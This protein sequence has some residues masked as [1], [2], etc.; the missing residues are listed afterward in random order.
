MLG[1]FRWRFLGYLGSSMGREWAARDWTDDWSGDCSP[2][3]KN[4]YHSYQTIL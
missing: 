4:S 3:V 2:Q 1:C